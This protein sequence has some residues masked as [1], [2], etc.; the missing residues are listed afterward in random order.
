MLTADAF[1]NNSYDNLSEEPWILVSGKNAKVMKRFQ[2]GHRNIKDIFDKIFQGI[3]SS[4]DSVY[5]L[6]SSKLNNGVY[7]ADSPELSKRVMVEVGLVKPLLL[8]DQV[9]RYQPIT[10]ENIVIFPY[11]LNGDETPE[12]MTE[13]YIATNFPLGY[14]YLKECEEILRGRERGRF[15]NSEW[16]QF[17]RKQGIAFGRFPKLLAPDISLG[18]NFTYDPQGEF[19]TTTTLYGYL[20]KDNVTERYEFWMTLLNSSLL[21]FYLKNS[22]SVLANGYYRY[23]PSYLEN[24]PVPEVSELSE[25]SLTVIANYLLVLNSSVHN[26]YHLTVSFLEQL[27]D[28]LV[29]ELYFPEEI[30]SAGKEILPHL[31]ELTPLTDEMSKEEKLAVI[32][33]GFERLYDPNHPVRNHLETLDNVEEV[34]IIQDSLRK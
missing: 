31:G 34:R 5:F 30:K 19:Y 7:E 25:T 1:T 27:I 12:L 3:A 32:Q 10:T 6:K 2:S 24:F 16:F 9:H 11:I 26:K 4:K 33:Q 17:G 20:I 18:G 28:G 21:W 22:G 15:D 14:S 23:K 29:Y 8:G 13:D